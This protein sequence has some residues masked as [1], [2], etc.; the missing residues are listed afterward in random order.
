MK[1]ITKWAALLFS[2]FWLLFILMD[3]WQKHPV[4]SFA[5]KHFSFQGFVFFLLL[6][7]TGVSWLVLK[8]GKKGK[9]SFLF[10]GLSIFILFLL[11]SVTSVGAAYNQIYPNDG[12]NGL[13][14]IHVLMLIGGTALGIYFIFFMCYIAGGWFNRLIGLSLNKKGDQMVLNLAC[15][16]MVVVMVM[17]LLG[18]F[19]LVRP[20]VL[21]PLFAVLVFFERKQALAFLKKTTMQPIKIK[22]N[23]NVV[24][25]GSFIGLVILI[26]FN[27]AAAC[28]PFPTGYDSLTFY[29]NLSS[30]IHQNAGLVVGY[31]PYNWSLFMSLG[32]V[33]FGSSEICLALSMIGGVFSL[34]AMYYIGRNSLGMDQNYSLL[35]LLLFYITQAV[36]VQSSGEF[37][38]DLGLLFIYL[39]VVILLVHYFREIA[40][41]K[42]EDEIDKPD[43]ILNPMIVVIGLLSG[44]ALAIKLTTLFFVFALVS[45]LWFVYTK[46]RGFAGV[47]LFCMF[48]V[49]LLKIDAA[50]GL[51]EYHMNVGYLQWGCLV[52]SLCLLAG[53]FWEQKK[54]M[55]KAIRSTLVFSVFFFLPVLPWVTKNAMEVGSF[56]PQ[57]LLT[58]KPGAPEINLQLL[59][60]N[61][62]N[63]NE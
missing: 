23:L 34:W 11:I 40:A 57:E 58:G 7:G 48:L 22:K 61:L 59:E 6:L 8:M 35:G 49:F 24:G 62:N 13:K 14:V 50:S 33:L 46:S 56:S 3:Y 10:N 25:I 9:M 60:Q 4:Y 31:Q 12:F 42:K 44:F 47:F 39:S 2:L 36:V 30:L 37:K 45:S 15:G 29:A 52:A 43:R 1:K 51:R 20:L 54:N 28:V 27:L 32:Y 38:I 21:F 16:I 53:A 19:S 26:G 17:F 41:W 55:I 18:V 5:F 63:P